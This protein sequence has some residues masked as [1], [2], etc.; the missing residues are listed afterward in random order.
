[1]DQ[2]IV[3][4]LA[5]KAGE[6]AKTVGDL[7]KSFEEARKAAQ[8]IGKQFGEDSK[9]YDKAV[10]KVEQLLNRF[11]EFGNNKKDLR[12]ARVLVQG[13]ADAYGATSVEAVTAAKAAANFKDNIGDADEL[14]AAFNP[15]KKFQAFGA[16]LQA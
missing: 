10:V 7:R 5:V 12:D 13:L 4:D 11:K 3:L 14:I 8:G 2:K 15:Y 6:A 9:E 16:A 1:M